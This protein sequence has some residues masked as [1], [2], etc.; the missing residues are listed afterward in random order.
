MMAIYEKNYRH[1]MQIIPDVRVLQGTVYSEYNN[2][3]V[4]F[5]EMLEQCRYTSILAITHYLSR[6]EQLLADFYMKLRVYHDARVAEVCDYQHQ[7]GL[8][9]VYSYPNKKMYQPY[10]KQQVNLFLEEWLQY[11][12]QYGC[13]FEQLAEPGIS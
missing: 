10:E 8:L 12:L 9:P 7:A 6:D 5:V 2:R 4:L 11:C 3:P 1:L 13:Q